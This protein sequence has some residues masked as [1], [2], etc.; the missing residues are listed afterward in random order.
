MLHFALQYHKD[1]EGRAGS[2]ISLH[3]AKGKAVHGSG[4]VI[5]EESASGWASH[6]LFGAHSIPNW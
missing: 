1:S 4:E 6:S 3:N 2:H 5:R